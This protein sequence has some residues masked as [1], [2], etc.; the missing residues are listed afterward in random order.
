MHKVRSIIVTGFRKQKKDI[1]LSLSEEANFLIG[2]NGTGKTSLINLINACLS[3]DSE[4]LQDTVF[5]DVTIKFK[6]QGKQTIPT[7][8]VEKLDFKKHGAYVR[9]SIKEHS[10]APF[11][12]YELSFG[13][14][15]MTIKDPDGYRRV[16]HKADDIRGLKSKL[17]SIFKHTWLSLHRG[18]DLIASRA[19]EDYEYD[20]E[21]MH[22]QSGVDRKLSAVLEELKNYYFTLDRKVSD[23]TREFQKDW[24]LSF[25]ATE[26]SDTDIRHIDIDFK[27]EKEAI[28]AIFK[29]LDLPKEAYETQ[30]DD[31]VK[32]GAEALDVF[33][34][35]GN[36]ALS[37]FFNAYDVVKLHRLVE[38]WQLLQEKQ[39]FTLEPKTDFIEIASSMLY[40]KKISL[41]QGNEVI[42][43]ADDKFDIR[44]DKL[45]SGEK[46]LIIF[47]AETIL[48]QKRPYIFLADEPELSLH[49][50]WQEQLVSNLLTVNPNAQ[51]LFATHSPDI[52]GKYSKH[53]FSMEEL[54]E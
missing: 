41:S 37:M 48:Q 8:F 43:D 25:L 50:E 19:H 14:R 9:Y 51:V 47:L 49:I 24:F 7:I 27:E 5:N 10:T 16:I 3:I 34:K 21:D 40:R 4:V 42:V 22:L 32:L 17:D 46:Q 12:V 18:H 54:S 6:K 35:E 30:L 11:E 15:R 13:R 53:I 44:I 23:Q 31:H 45:S 36:F 52:V 28:S 38:Q 33:K 2:R 26:G 20:F 29:R 39:K 1:K